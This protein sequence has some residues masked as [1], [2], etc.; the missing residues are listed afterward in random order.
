MRKPAPS[1]SEIKKIADNVKS[2]SSVPEAQT[3]V[4]WKYA[5]KLIYEG[6]INSARKYIDLA[7]RADAT[8]TFK[9]KKIFWKD[10]KIQIKKSPYY[11][12]L[13]SYFGL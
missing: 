11:N 12:D 4:P 13:S 3:N 2:W 10:L 7:W 8:R 5:I 9:T 1:F 6:N